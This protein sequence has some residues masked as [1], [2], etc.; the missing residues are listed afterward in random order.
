MG[1]VKLIGLNNMANVTMFRKAF[2]PNY[3]KVLSV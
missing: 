3:L 1:L 2:V